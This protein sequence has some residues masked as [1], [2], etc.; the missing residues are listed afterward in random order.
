MKEIKAI[1]Q[2]FMLQKVCDALRAIDGLPGVTVSQVMGWGKGRGA[3]ASETVEEGGCTFVRKTKLE[4]VVPAAIADEVVTAIA[5][6]ART[7]NMGD[8]KI[9][10]HDLSE[11]VKIR[12]GDRGEGAI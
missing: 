9:F 11:V 8:G 3:G 2:P 4:V 12:T 1:I 7:G 10:V 6:A 5:A